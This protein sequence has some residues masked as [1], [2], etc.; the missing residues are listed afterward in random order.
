MG[1][2]DTTEPPYVWPL[3]EVAPQEKVEYVVPPPPM[4]KSV[5]PQTVETASM[6]SQASH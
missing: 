3:S 6:H 1:F 2:G 4:P 5:L